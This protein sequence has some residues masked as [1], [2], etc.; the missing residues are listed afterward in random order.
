[1]RILR[2][3]SIRTEN[4]RKWTFSFEVTEYVFR[5]RVADNIYTARPVKKTIFGTRKRANAFVNILMNTGYMYSSKIAYGDQFIYFLNKI[6]TGIKHKPGSWTVNNKRLGRPPKKKKF[7]DP[8]K[9]VFISALSKMSY[10][11]LEDQKV[12][13][14]KANAAWDKDVVSEFLETA[15]IIKVGDEAYEEEEV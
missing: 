6:C 15:Y 8:T 5:P 14:E 7:N 11:F 12:A 2:T 13:L 1:M 10:K 3:R 4:N 9:E